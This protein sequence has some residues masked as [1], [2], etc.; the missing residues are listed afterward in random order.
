MRA[1]LVSLLVFLAALRVD[2]A[3]ST[4]PDMPAVLVGSANSSTSASLLWT[5]S[6]GAEGY[7]VQELVLDSWVPAV[8]VIGGAVS[9]QVQ[10][11]APGTVYYFRVVARNEAG[12]SVP[13]PMVMVH[14]WAGGDDPASGTVT[15]SSRAASAMETPAGGSVILQV[16]RTGSV[17]AAATVEYLLHPGT[18]TA[19]E[20]FVGTSGVVRFAPGEVTQTIAIELVADGVIESEETFSVVLL[21]PQGLALGAI[22]EATVTILDDDTPVLGPGS[23]AGLLYQAESNVPEGLITFRVAAKGGI[24]GTVHLGRQR[25][26][27]TTRLDE[28]GHALVPAA[29]KPNETGEQIV[30]SVN[31]ERTEFTAS[32]TDAQGIAYQSSGA[33]LAAAEDIEA[34]FL[35]RTYTGALQEEGAEHVVAGV[36]SM[37]INK[38]GITKLRGY[39]PN[40]R[41]L[42]A[43]LFL[44]LEGEAL[45]AQRVQEGTLYGAVATEGDS[46]GQAT[47]RG[48]VWWHETPKGG[49]AKPVLELLANLSRFTPGPV[50][51]APQGSP[52]SFEF[53]GGDELSMEPIPARWT[54]AV[55]LNGSSEGMTAKLN[56]ASAAGT[57]K[58]YVKDA[59]GEAK[60]LYGVVIQ[61]PNSDFM[62]I[63]GFVGGDPAVHHW[64]LG[65]TQP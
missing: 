16:Q 7:E 57:A 3:A 48:Q 20:D 23:F 25:H 33:R 50:L 32:Y 31:R 13:S 65:P 28:A 21:N 38:R 17:N 44:T 62:E 27:F 40:G 18:A 4:P 60:K 22:V 55:S 26:P 10:G 41:P 6:P 29:G 56:I 36:A 2:L 34:S 39:A 19:G 45:I 51:I 12:G 8:F 24:S 52:L 53:V 43:A 61:P 42:S 30:L 59:S 37:K 11:L 5:A 9:C 47:F 63:I 46:E 15:L 1:L 54:S 35:G 64:T 49:E 58:G 14:T